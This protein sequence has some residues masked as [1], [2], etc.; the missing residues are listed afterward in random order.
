LAANGHLTGKKFIGKPVGFGKSTLESLVINKMTSLLT[1]HYRGKR[2]LVTGHTGFKG[3][4]LTEWLLTL[5]A[6]VT[7]LALSPNTCPALFTQLELNS[8]L[9]HIVGDV[10]DLKLVRQVVESVRPDFIFHLAAQPLVRLSY[11][12]PVE[13]FSTNVMG[14]INVLEAIRLAGHPCSVVA[15]TT[16]KCYENKEWVHSYR[17]EDAMGGRDPYSASK[18]A[19]EIAIAAYRCSYFSAPDSPVRLAS[20]RAGNVIGGGDWAMDRIVPDTIRALQSGGKIAVRNKSSTRPW[21]HVLEPLSGYLFLG[22]K[23]QDRA[24][25]GAYNFG[26]TLASNR[27]VAELVEEM[28]RHWPGQWEDRSEPGASHEAGRLNLAIDKAYHLLG[29]KPVWDFARTVQETVSWYRSCRGDSHIA[30]Q[31]ITEQ[32]KQYTIEARNEGLAWAQDRI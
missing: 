23:L 25:A 26:P 31:L 24:L 4:W 27:T 32:I 3:A 7:G 14:T 9:N 1:A 18:G 10:R 22:I 11:D 15:V 29:W 30:Q 17:E 16:D 20:T 8:R 12:Q 19:A 13:T 28:L 2:V 6:E 21:Q 5:G